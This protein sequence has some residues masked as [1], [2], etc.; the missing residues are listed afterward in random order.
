MEPTVSSH[1]LTCF[2]Q[3]PIARG[4]REG[5]WKAKRYGDPQQRGSNSRELSTNTWPFNC[6]H[7]APH[8]MDCAEAMDLNTRYTQYMG[9]NRAFDCVDF[10][11]AGPVK[12]S[13]LPDEASIADLR[14]VDELPT[15]DSRVLFVPQRRLYST[16]STSVQ[17]SIDEQAWTNLLTVLMIPPNVVELLHE[18]NG[19]SWQHSSECSDNTK[20]HGGNDQDHS[21]PCAYHI[22]FK[23]SQFELMYARHD[24]HTKR[25]LV[26]IMGV[27]L[28][29]ES[30]RLVSQF[31]GLGSVHLFHILLAIL[32]TW[33]QKLE[34]SRWSLDFAVLQ[35]EQNTG[36]GQVFHRVQP[37]PP[38]QLREL[39]NDTAG[40]Q[41]YIRSVARHSVCTGERLRAL[42]EALPKFLA[43]QPCQE[44]HWEVQILDTLGQYQTQTKVTS[45]SSKRTKP[46]Q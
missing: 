40:A 12:H 27:S 42:R 22:C 34:H 14:I 38:H 15:W 2:S 23:A 10:G 18:N 33:L 19:G 17:I 6:R 13:V 16:T 20:A 11:G 30:Q 25:N 31:S 28:E 39:R 7:F 5:P 24:F 44:L 46:T 3:I 8:V 43:L 45:R 1:V 36:Y 9:A 32:G 37:L 35:L 4:W 21:G 26:L 29:R 41:G